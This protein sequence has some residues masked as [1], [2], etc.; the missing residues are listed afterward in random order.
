MD[1]TTK[2]QQLFEINEYSSKVKDSLKKLKE[3]QEPGQLTGKVSKNA[4]LESNKEK[5]YELIKNGYTTKQIAEA[6][7]NDVFKVSQKSITQ[8]VNSEAN[9]KNKRQKREPLKMEVS[10]TN[11]FIHD[12]KPIK[13]LI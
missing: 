3:T 4:I 9:K 11:K 6:L 10:S 1:E 8:L 5:I 7:S 12:D 13:D 2:K